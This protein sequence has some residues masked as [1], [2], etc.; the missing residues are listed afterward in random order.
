MKSS[1][2]LGVLLA[3]VCA[4]IAHAGL[5][6]A[7]SW[8]FQGDSANGLLGNGGVVFGDFN[9]DGFRDIAMAAPDRSGAI[10]TNGKVYVFLGSA[11]GLATIP[12]WTA[13]GDQSGAE[14]GGG[15]L[16]IGDFNGD[17]YSDLVVGASGE[18]VNGH[19]DAGASYLWYGGPAGPGNPSG[20]GPDGTTASADWKL[21]G[22]QDGEFLGAWNGDAGDV[23]G[24]GV[25]DLMIG[26]PDFTGATGIE[27]HEGKLFVFHGAVTGVPTT[28][29]WTAEGKQVEAS[30]GGS[31]HTAHDVNHDGFDDIVVSS[32]YETPASFECPGR[33]FVWLGSATGLG[34]NGT[35]SN[36]D[37]FATGDPSG[38]QFGYWVSSLDVNGDH[39]S[40]IAIGGPAETVNG[41]TGAGRVYVWL[42]GPSG[43]GNPSGLGPNGT[44]ANADWKA[45]GD[46]TDGHFGYLAE[47]AGDVNKDGY[48]DL[49]T[50]T[51]YYAIDGNPQTGAAWVY[52]GSPTG[53]GPTGTTA[54]AD[55][56]VRGTDGGEAYGG[57]AHTV[58]DI[59]GDG[60]QDLWVSA[61]AATVD[62]LTSAGIAWIYLGTCGATDGDGDGVS[63]TGTPGCAPTDLTDCNDGDGGSWATPGEATG[64]AFAA[65]KQTLS[66]SAVTIGGTSASMRYDL[67]RSS[68]PADFV[69]GTACVASSIA[70]TSAPDAGT[71]T[72]GTLFAYLARAKNGCP[73]A[74]GVGTLG[75]TSA[76]ATRAGISC[77]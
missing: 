14:F 22:T 63:P 37:W 67:L 75:T 19:V 28:P 6:T 8:S 7:P 74:G 73:G 15:Q 62:G 40:D 5:M 24:D 44:P 13:E 11:A 59:N 20:L 25:Q 12:A 64:L 33:V 31:F 76:G 18:D 1:R 3:G 35:P 32:C 48:E 57:D 29:S 39:F 17:G 65:D 30:L 50:T 23:N 43:T 49:V 55:W 54:N 51:Y 71:P 10:P 60:F 69:N 4:S 26:A 16:G 21:L 66:W 61:P 34:P 72:E 70:T 45:E 77:P 36:A 52:F 2:I 58:R 41:V 38:Y 68:N 46:Q 56:N 53:L 47:I 27:T 9:K 42:G